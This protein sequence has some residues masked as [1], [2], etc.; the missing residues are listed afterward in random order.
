MYIIIFLNKLQS[1][2]T[3]DNTHCVQSTDKLS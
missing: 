1:S 3:F 2:D